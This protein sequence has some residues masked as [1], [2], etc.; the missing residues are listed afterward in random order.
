VKRPRKSDRLPVCPSTWIRHAAKTRRAGRRWP[1]LLVQATDDPERSWRHYG[2][3]DDEDDLS[4][5]A[6]RREPQVPD[7]YRAIGEPERD[8]SA[9]RRIELQTMTHPVRVGAHIWPGGASSYATWRDAVLRAE[10]RDLRL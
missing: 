7:C 8:I 5:N 9:A 2:G 10:Q 6:D 1:R 4:P 3:R